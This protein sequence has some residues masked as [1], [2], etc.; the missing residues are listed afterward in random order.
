MVEVFINIPDVF[1]GSH[2]AA[3]VEFREIYR[4]GIA[5]ERLLATAVQKIFVEIGHHQLADGFI[6][7]LAVPQDRVVGFGDCAPVIVDFKN[8]NGVVIIRLGCL[9]VND[10]RV[11]AVKAQGCGRKQRA[12]QA[13][14][15]FMP[16]DQPGRIARLA[17][18]FKIKRQGLQKILDLGRGG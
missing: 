8:R 1:C 2:P 17:S 3:A 16:Q 15:C 18:F 7:W 11:M 10:E 5:A 14:R 4:I 13:V 9:K 6:N 12:L